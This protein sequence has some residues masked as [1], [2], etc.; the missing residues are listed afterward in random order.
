MKRHAVR[1]ASVM[2]AV[3]ALTAGCSLES[4]SQSS[5]VVNVVVGYQSK[6]IN[7]V[8][9]GTLLRAQGYLEH[10]LVDITARTGTKYAVRWQDY[11]TG[12]PITAQMLAEKIDIGSMGDYP[13]LINGSK[14]QSSPLARTEI[15]S[16]TGYN[17]KGALNMVV[18]TPDSRAKGLADLAGAK[19]S[20]SVG[21]AGHGTLV[22]ALSRACRV[23]VCGVEVL[24]Q[25]PQVGASALESGQVQALSQFVAWPGLLVYQG[26]A[27]LLYDGAELNLPTLHGV[28]VRRSYASAH[29]EV[30]G[31]FLQAQ[32]DA[33]DFLNDKPLQA[34]R[35][36]AKESGLPQEVVY[37]Y[38]GP[39][40]TS[41]DT[42]LK[43]S[44][45]EALKSDVPYLKSIGDFAD[46]DVAKF[47]VDEPLRTVFTARG[48]DYAASRARTANPSALRGDP[49]QA[50]ELWLDGA[51]ATQTTAT[52]TGL[53]RAVRDAVARGARVRAAYVPD[54]ELGT[55]WFADKAFWVKDGRNYLP[56]GTAAGATRYLAGHP[57]GVAMD[58]QEA[59]GGSV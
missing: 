37:L 24:N 27:K 52:P 11:D 21:S 57:E 56:F 15:V 49:A 18:V 4:L 51:D 20:A 44:L 9:A 5:G 13:M 10:R 26:K 47:V 29:P 14:T 25:Q 30:L 54:A 31:A 46:L 45:V 53:L 34:A 1:P 19:V 23:G 38:N 58:Y 50:S 42:T 55:R 39:G 35:I 41:F 48:L 16:I 3:A 32:L 17:P 7:T 22:R 43:P 59:L 33:T 36:V 12:A 2:I 6:T 28:V 40:G 8:T